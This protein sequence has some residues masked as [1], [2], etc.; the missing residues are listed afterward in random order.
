MG[1]LALVIAGTADLVA[2]FFLVS[3]EEYILL[4]PGMMVLIYAAIGMRGNIFG[5]MGS[6]LGTAMH[7][8][9]FQMSLRK[10]SVLR[11][12]VEAAMALTLLMSVLMA[13]IGWVIVLVFFGETYDFLKF[14][15]ISTFGGLLAG[16]LVMVV[17]L[18]V[19]YVGYKRNWDVDNITAPLIAAAGDV[20][21]VPMIYVA[22]LA[23]VNLE[24]IV[25]QIGAIVLV[26]LTVLFTVRI[27][28][29]KS[30][31]K[32]KKDEAKRIIVQSL[33]VLLGCV[34]LELATGILIENEEAKL[35]EYAVLM[36]M[37][38]AFLN[39]GN[40]LSGMLTSRIS[41]MFHMGTMPRTKFPP[42][43]T[44]D[45]YSMMYML[46]LVTFLYIMGIAF[47]VKSGDIEFVTLLTIVLIS[48]LIITTIINILSYYVAL[49]A[50]KFRL[51]PDD[52]CIPITSSL[53]DVISTVVL[54]AVISF[55]I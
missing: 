23:A 2:G 9:T 4:V 39:E 7:L 1:L 16:M 44:L 8:G 36:L 10:K 20:I 28:T 38:T 52:H 27:V 48:A 34:F 47:A 31:R 41:S 51:D 45:N 50:L 43:E 3:M 49:A 26:V 24:D 21:T 22:T 33:P 40:A 53:M 11:A 29:R 30:K 32:R 12:N 5:A 13:I 42:R 14:V 46:A 19:A 35:I 18:A 6:R 55:F 17:N 54:M 25:T 15:F 37:M